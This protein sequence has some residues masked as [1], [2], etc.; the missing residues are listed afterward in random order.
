M[1]HKCL[2]ETKRRVVLE[3]GQEQHTGRQSLFPGMRRN[4]EET[5]VASNCLFLV[6]IVV[7]VVVA[8]GGLSSSSG[9]L[10][11]VLYLSFKL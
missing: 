5:R 9:S 11:L 3:G 6:V 1:G 7:V 10:F 4:K 8:A 2:F